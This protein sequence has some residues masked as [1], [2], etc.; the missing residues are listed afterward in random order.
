VQD[1]G[2]DACNSCPESGSLVGNS[3]VE[4]V[5][6]AAATLID[7][8]PDTLPLSFWYPDAAP[9]AANDVAATGSE[10]V[11]VPAVVLPSSQC[12]C[13]VMPVELPASGI[14]P[15]ACPLTVPEPEPLQAAH[16]LPL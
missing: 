15:F 6:A 14:T 9:P 7:A 11:T 2:A 16:V 4:G 12:D 8:N 13:A 1:D 3:S 10:H 5:P